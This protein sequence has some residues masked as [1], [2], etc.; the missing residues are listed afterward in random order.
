MATRAE[1]IRKIE[2]EIL[3]G[4]LLEWLPKIGAVATPDDWREMWTL[5]TRAGKL[6]ITT[7]LKPYGL[8]THPHPT[9]FSCFEDPALATSI[10][11]HHQ[12]NRHSGKWNF[13][14]EER[15]GAGRF[16]FNDFKIQ[17]TAILGDRARATP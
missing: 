4:M 13:H 9:I 15:E 3:R 17:L 12:L 8:N 10:L 11:G 7:F 2:A 5:E 14:G 6:T 16:V 1:R